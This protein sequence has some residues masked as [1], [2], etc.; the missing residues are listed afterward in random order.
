MATIACEPAG[1]ISPGFGT[2]LPGLEPVFDAMA[3]FIDRH[4]EAGFLQ[5]LLR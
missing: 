4:F 2:S 5:N 1:P 3:D